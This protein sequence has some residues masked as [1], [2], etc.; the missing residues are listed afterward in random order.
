LSR[1]TWR[2]HLSSNRLSGCSHRVGCRATE[3]PIS[4]RFSAQ[5]GRGLRSSQREAV[6]RRLSGG[7]GIDA[8]FGCENETLRPIHRSS[9]DGKRITDRFTSGLRTTNESRTGSP[10]VFGRQT[11]HGSIHQPPSGSKRITGAQTRTSVQASNPNRTGSPVTF[12][13]R[14]SHG[15]IHQSSSDYERIT[16]RFTSHLRA[17]NEPR[18]DSPVVFGLRTNHGPVHQS[19]SGGKRA[20]AR[21]TSLLR[22][23]NE[24][25]ERKLALRCKRATPTGL[26]HQSPSGDE[27]ATDR[28]TSCLRIANESSE[29]QAF[30]SMSA[31]GSR[32]SSPDT[33][34]PN[35]LRVYI[36][37]RA[38]TRRC[39]GSMQT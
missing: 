9:S 10:A 14:K 39:R 11:S 7:R 1:A 5:K 30:I 35:E 24:S 20:T 12:G 2:R 21:F 3:L 18:T 31:R 32:K 17:A 19:P 29:P 16:D 8:C 6:P 23:A 13:R 22:E 25:R 36:S 15:P 26:V 34:V 33:S 27:R 38:V 4:V 37:A 28:F